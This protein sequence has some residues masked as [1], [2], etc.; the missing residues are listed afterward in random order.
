MFVNNTH[1][2]TQM[3]LNIRGK[4]ERQLFVSDKHKNKSPTHFSKCKV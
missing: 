1:T 3:D 4:N 2:D